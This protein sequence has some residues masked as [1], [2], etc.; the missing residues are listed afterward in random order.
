MWGVVSEQPFPIVK[1][2]VANENV[3]YQDA[4]Q[5]EGERMT[6]FKNLNWNKE[7]GLPDGEPASPANAEKQAC[8]LD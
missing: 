8:S 7:C 1:Q 2:I 5:D 3:D 4:A 6:E